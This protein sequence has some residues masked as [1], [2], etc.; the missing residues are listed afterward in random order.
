MQLPSRANFQQ[1]IYFLIRRNEIF[2]TGKKSLANN[3]I[4]DR[5]L[6]IIEFGAI[7]MYYSEKMFNIHLSCLQKE[8]FNG[9]LPT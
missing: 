1:I 3:R 7:V 8:T 5:Y 2:C 9:T 4:L 6:D